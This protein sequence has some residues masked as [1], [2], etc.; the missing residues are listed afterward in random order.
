MPA[1]LPHP[2][3]P[4]A[5]AR[6]AAAARNARLTKPPGALGRLEAVM[7]QLAGSQG[8]AL[9]SCQRVAIL[10]FAADH[11]V[12][13]RG[14]S[15]FPPAVTAQ[16]CHNFAAGGAAIS[17]LARSLGA[18]LTV[19]DAGV[20]G[21]LDPALPMVH[22]P[23]AAGTADFVDAPA[24]TP[25][26]ADAALALGIAQ[27]EAAVARGGELLVPGE[28]GIGN[29]TSA[30]ALLAALAGLAAAAAVAAGT[31][32]AGAVLARKL[33]AVQAGLEIGRAHV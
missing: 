17:V 18:E 29:T 28:M 23:I 19:V 27:A 9:P 10:V 12:A 7:L 32:A 13:A 15:A 11:G 6:A 30:A 3:A 24:M 20:A 21:G 25:D 4:D 33:D 1:P 8:R 2:A 31:G 5:A 16:M 22:A 14:V 26:Q